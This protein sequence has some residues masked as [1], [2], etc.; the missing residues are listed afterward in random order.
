MSFKFSCQH[1]VMWQESLCNANKTS[2]SPKDEKTQWLT[3]TCRFHSELPKMIKKDKVI[4]N[5]QTCLRKSESLWIFNKTGKRKLSY[6]NPRE[7][8]DL[9]SRGVNESFGIRA[10]NSYVIMPSCKHIQCDNRSFLISSVP[11]SE[12]GFFV[13][14]MVCASV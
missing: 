3:L 4:N 9:S 7:A 6:Y 2:A 1:T 5:C 11:D 12:T 13:L 8:V 10:N 14:W